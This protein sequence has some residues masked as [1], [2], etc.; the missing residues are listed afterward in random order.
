MI[1]SG[2]TSTKN[3]SGSERRFLDAMRRIGFGRFEGLQIRNGE[4]VLD[5]WPTT[6]RD[7]K[8]GSQG[9]Q[10]VTTTGEFPLKQE[11]VELFEFV[12]SVADGR[13]RILEIRHGLPHLMEVTLDDTVNPEGTRQSPA[14]AFGPQS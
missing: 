5:P 3:L 12:R 2:P 13:I 8:F 7:V 14:D 6:V 1:K 11:V 4:L 10:Q 9:G